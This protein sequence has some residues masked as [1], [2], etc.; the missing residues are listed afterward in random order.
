MYKNTSKIVTF[1]DLVAWKKA[2]KLSLQVYKFTKNF[3]K[4]ELYGLTSQMRRSSVSVSS[5]I[6]EGFA[7]NSRKGKIQFYS[8]SKGSLFE[9]QSQIKLSRDL[10]YIS[11]NVFVETLNLT[12]ES[13]ALILGLIKSSTSKI[14]T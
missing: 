11:Q 9:L 13:L 1:F 4:E 10:N 2:H 5:N 3:P 12:N 6:A 8:I 14:N 7:M